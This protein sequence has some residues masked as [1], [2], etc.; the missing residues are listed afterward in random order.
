MELFVTLTGDAPQI[1]LQ[2]ALGDRVAAMLNNNIVQVL[3]IIF[4]FLN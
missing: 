2:E 4:I 1:F 3:I